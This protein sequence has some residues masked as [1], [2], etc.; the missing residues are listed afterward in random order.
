MTTAAEER[1]GASDVTRARENP[2]SRKPAEHYWGNGSIPRGI[3][4]AEDGVEVS[5]FAIAI[6]VGRARVGASRG[7]E[8]YLGSRGHS[9]SRTARSKTTAKGRRQPEILALDL[10]GRDLHWAALCERAIAS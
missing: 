5:G 8:R 6:F 3:A 7:L 9:P 2:P 1:N 4:R 10:P